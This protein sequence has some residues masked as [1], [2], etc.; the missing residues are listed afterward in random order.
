[1]IIE[2]IDF[3]T[4]SLSEDHA[5]LLSLWPISS[6]TIAKAAQIAVHS[7]NVLHCCMLKIKISVV[8]CDAIFSSLYLYAQLF[9]FF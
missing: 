7:N 6:I 5:V 1:M 9:R 4:E 2:V 3:A 8:K